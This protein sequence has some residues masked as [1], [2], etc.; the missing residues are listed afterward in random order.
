MTKK[1]LQAHATAKPLSAEGS[2][3]ISCLHPSPSSTTPAC[4]V[5]TPA[6]PAA[7]A[8]EQ[9]LGAALWPQL[10][11]SE[12]PQGPGAREPACPVWV[13]PYVGALVKPPHC[14]RGSK[15]ESKPLAPRQHG[16]ESPSPTH[17]PADAAGDEAKGRRGG[18]PH[19]AAQ[20]GGP[21]PSRKAE[22]LRGGMALGLC[23]CRVSESVNRKRARGGCSELC[24]YH[25]VCIG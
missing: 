11:T 3:P 5:A 21:V 22:G 8:C 12:D 13:H 18:A 23:V 17:A 10:M 14:C 2:A 9:R 16:R 25:L 19:R 7:A 6:G 20:G 1:A 15:C 24:S 4:S